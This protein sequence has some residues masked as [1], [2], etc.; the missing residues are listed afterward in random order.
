MQAIVTEFNILNQAD[1][2]NETAST[3]LSYKQAQTGLGYEQAPTDPGYEQAATGLGY[4]N[5]HQL[6]WAINKH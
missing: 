6:V 2:V 4:D 5:K 3:G 1:L